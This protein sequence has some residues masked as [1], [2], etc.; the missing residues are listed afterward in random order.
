MSSFEPVN[1]FPV[2]A[3]DDELELKTDLTQATNQ[4]L[5]F[6]RLLFERIERGLRARDRAFESDVELAQ[7]RCLQLAIRVF[8]RERAGDARIAT[9]FAATVTKAHPEIVGKA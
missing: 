5:N 2:C 4:T 1:K 6:G 7:R 9:V 3:G 8:T